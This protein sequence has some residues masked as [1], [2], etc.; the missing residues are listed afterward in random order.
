M[1]GLKW[2]KVV[3]VSCGKQNTAAITQRG[4]VYTWGAN[5]NGQLGYKLV[6]QGTK[7]SAVPKQVA[8]LDFEGMNK[9]EEGKRRGKKGKN[10]IKRTRGGAKAVLFISSLILTVFL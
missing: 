3:Y 2:N 5:S 7:N 9:R 10:G 6:P 4:Q 8:E 1:E